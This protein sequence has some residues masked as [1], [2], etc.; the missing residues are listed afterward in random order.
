MIIIIFKYFIKGIINLPIILFS[1]IKHFLIG[2]IITIT[3][4]PRYFII[5]IRY[6][7]NQKTRDEIKIKNK[8]LVPIMMISLSLSIYF[9]SV[10]LFS[11]WYV[12]EL[13]LKYLAN[14]IISSTEIIEKTEKEEENNSND[15]D[16]NNDDETN[17]STENSSNNTYYPNDYWDYINVPY[18]DVNFN[19]L[20]QKNSD[21]VAWLKVEGTNVNYP[22]VQTT[23]NSYYLSHDYR[24]NANAGGWIFGDYRAN[25]KDFKKNTI[26]YGHNLNNKT[27]FGSIPDSVLSSRWQKN[28]SN[29]II[30]MSTPTS[31]T[32]WKIFSVYTIEPETYYLK[33]AFSTDS[34]Q[35]FINTIK[36]RSVYDFNTDITTNDKI[37]TLST[38]DNI[39]TKRVVVHAKLVK[40]EQK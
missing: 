20:L 2:L 19:S 13:K 35:E 29:H 31:N 14:D 18:I 27:M 30:K 23:D 12:Q 11:R 10:F 36:N 8:P 26:I 4:I 17:N 40:I 38:C 1:I 21:T 6:I 34:F 15:N 32:I 3:I 39:G 9:L 37:L 16:D 22:V 28:E 25:F 5:G 24:K 33:T 7:F